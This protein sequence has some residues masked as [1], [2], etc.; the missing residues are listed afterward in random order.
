MSSANVSTAAGRKMPAW[1]RPVLEWARRGAVRF[2]FQLVTGLLAGAL[3]YF[4]LGALPYYPPETV[5]FIAALA[6]AAWW[7]HSRLGAFVTL[8]VFVLPIAYQSPTLALVYGLFFL[9]VS[10]LEIET[11]GAY[12]FLTLAGATA[13]ACLP[14]GNLFLLAVPLLAGF[15]GAR[16]GALLG[17]IACLWL[18]LLGILSGQSQV[19]PVLLGGQAVSPFSLVLKPLASLLDFGW[20]ASWWEVRKLDN[21]LLAAL[22]APL[23]QRP[24]LWVQVALWAAAAGLVGFLLSKR[25]GSKIP[26]RYLALAAGLLA[27]GAGTW[28]LAALFG[29]GDWNG[30]ARLV[31]ILVP[32]AGVFLL[33]PLLEFLA[34]RKPLPVLKISQAHESGADPQ[35]RYDVF[36]SHSSKD[37]LV[38]EPIRAGLEDAGL[39]CWIAPRDILPGEDFP[40]AIA[41][42]IASSRLMLLVFTLNSNLSEEVSRELYLAASRQR[43]ILPFR[44]DPVEPEPG[45]AYYLSRIEWLD[46]ARPP[47]AGQIAA[48]AQRIQA[49][50]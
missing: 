27:L 21:D 34:L 14:Q 39:R 4:L 25:L 15:L 48:L 2:L 5:A 12:G 29:Q 23:A 46:A 9:L 17:G 43:V 40:S 44:V 6:G 35:F 38:V 20:L 10:I 37:R 13:A 3:V 26:G 49:L 31:P 24:V 11:L 41:T 42:A 8:A 47:T 28:T 18:E 30:G 7:V 50:L 1:F 19:G 32:A 36:I 22:F 33:S 16:R 45:K